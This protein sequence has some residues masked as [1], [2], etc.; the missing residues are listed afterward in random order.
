MLKRLLN[1]TKFPNKELQTFEGIHKICLQM[2]VSQCIIKSA[3]K[4]LF[5]TWRHISNFIRDGRCYG[6]F[7]NN[8]LISYIIF[9]LIGN[10]IEI[11]HGF[12][13]KSFRNNGYIK[14]LVKTIY[15]I[16]KPKN[17]YYKKKVLF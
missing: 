16:H 8:R 3:S 12:T 13:R 17:I 14:E 1:N 7:I 2:D 11:I 15:N 6:Y 5:V 9:D 10:D 4:K